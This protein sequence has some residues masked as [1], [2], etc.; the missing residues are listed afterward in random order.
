MDWVDAPAEAC[1]LA[2]LLA[3]RGVL[4]PT[5]TPPPTLHPRERAR[6]GGGAGG[7]SQLEELVLAEQQKALVQSVIARL[8]EMAFDNCI[9]KPS[10]SLSSTEQGCIQVHTM[11]PDRVLIRGLAVPHLN[12]LSRP[13]TCTYGAHMYAGDGGQ[14]PRHVRVR[15]GPRAAPGPRRQDV[16]GDKATTRKAA[17]Q[18]KTLTNSS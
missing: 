9:A 16:K 7:M 3:Y 18:R 5:S 4:N 14:V 12:P 15:A 17:R 11:E 1:A 10:S 8:T 2:R 13:T 6:A